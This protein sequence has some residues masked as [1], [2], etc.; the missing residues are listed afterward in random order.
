MKKIVLNIILFLFA[1]PVSGQVQTKKPLTEKD[2]TLWGRLQTNAISDNGNWISYRMQYDSG[3]DTLFISHTKNNTKHFFTEAK[4]GKFIKEEAFAFLQRNNLVLFNLN[5]EIKI[6]INDVERFEISANNKFI[7]SEEKSISKEKN[8]C[9]RNINGQLL[10]SLK[11][12]S[13]YRWDDTKEHI[14]WISSDSISSIGIISLQNKV[15]N[16]V[17][18]N[19]SGLVY[20]SP[21]WQRNAE[22]FAFYGFSPESETENRIYYYH[23]KEKKIYELLHTTPDIPKDGSVININPGTPLLISNDGNSL[24]FEIKK[25]NTEQELR[26]TDVEIWYSNDKLLYPDRKLVSSKKEDQF[27]AVW[28]PRTS[29]IRQITDKEHSWVRLTG[30]QRYALTANP[31]QYQPQ[32][33]LFADKDYYLTELSTGNKMLLLEKHSGQEAMLR[34]SPC[35]KYITYYKDSSWWIYDIDLKQH[36]NLTEGLFTDW[37]NSET[38]P[39]NQ[40]IVWGLA[41]WSKDNK[42]VLYYDYYDI[43]LIS[44]DGKKRQRLTKGREIKVRFR[45]EKN[46]VEVQRNY[47]GLE[48]LCINL[49]GNRILSAFNLYN[50]NSGYYILTSDKEVIPFIMDKGNSGRLLK[51]NNNE[52]IIFERERFDNPPAIIFK[53]DK[54]TKEKLLF[55]SNIH[56][57]NYQWGFSEM[58]HYNTETGKE[59]NGALFYPADYE[60][61]KK[62]PMI[63]WVYE[64]VSRSLHQYINPSMKNSLG[65]NIANLTSK[66]YFVL[67]ADIDFKK[68]SPG[69][70]A[71]ECVTAAVNKVEEMGYI[72]SG[73]IGLIGHSFGGYETNFIIS[74]TDIFS[75]AISGSGVSDIIQHYFTVNSEDNKVDAWRYE[76]QQYRMGVPF[77]DNYEAYFENS[78]LIQAKNINTPLLTW[79]GLLDENVQPKQALTFYAALRRLKKKHIMLRYPDE[80][81][82]LFK[83]KNQIDITHRVQQW[84]DH[85][86]NKEPASE[87]IEKIIE[88]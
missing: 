49:K 6:T 39:G 27:T 55:Q 48:L 8:L 32:Y 58:I 64:T 38:D 67:L 63:V 79:T 76:N 51:A 70:S 41:G 17:I 3:I 24:L 84:F 21:Q 25:P 81:H 29:M 2:Y 87:W 44:V 45:F 20:T 77:Y 36:K 75:A 13:E 72:E 1:C 82:I 83:T 40:L 71:V 18:S 78:P 85:F 73:K 23:S 16:T 28:Y 88:D 5:P 56:H 59:L 42:S 35:G 46:D 74:Q 52:A 62:Y 68:G 57:T 10:Y 31:L 37:D 19:S 61:T 34:V 11:N 15:K 4:E 54:N 47:S 60:S 43:W 80:G 14:I 50:G 7:V 22:S 69:K 86:L 30:D 65:F 26:D 33:K 53:K 9:I 12:I 66:G